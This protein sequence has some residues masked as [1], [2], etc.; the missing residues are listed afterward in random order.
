MNKNV[1]RV[2]WIGGLA[3]AAGAIGF[4]FAKLGTPKAPPP[5]PPPL[6]P[7]DAALKKAQDDAAAAAAVVAKQI[8]GQQ[9]AVNDYAAKAAG[10]TPEEYVTAVAKSGNVSGGSH[11]F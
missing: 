4:V 11:G 7:V 6:S 8:A 1:E 3:V 10:M 5:P 2:A 9:K